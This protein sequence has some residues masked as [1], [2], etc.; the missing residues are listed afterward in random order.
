MRERKSQRNPRG[1]MLFI[2]KQD[3]SGRARVREEHEGERG[4]GMRAYL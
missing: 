3:G 2:R 1:C 4:G